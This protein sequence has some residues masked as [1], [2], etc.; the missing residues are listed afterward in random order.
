MA[1]EKLYNSSQPLVLRWLLQV[2]EFLASL[3]LAVVLI[4]S[5]AVVLAFATVVESVVGTSGVQ[6]AIY[7]TRAFAALL[8][9]LAI[10]IFCAASVRFPWK[11]H[12]TG[13]VITHIGLLTLLAGSAYSFR[14]SLNSQMIVFLNGSSQTA[15][16]QDYGYIV[17]E[18]LPNRDEALTINF[19]PGPFHWNEPEYSRRLQQIKLFIR[20]FKSPT[21]MVKAA[22]GYDDLALHEPELLHEQEGLKVEAIDYYA[23]AVNRRLP[24]VELKFENPGIGTKFPMQLAYREIHGGD[25]Q[26]G[27]RRE[28]FMGLGSVLYWREPDSPD[29]AAFLECVPEVAVEGDGAVVVWQAGELFHIPIAQLQTLADR[30]AAY[31]LEDGWSVQLV[32][33][34]GARRVAPTQPLYEKFAWK[35]AESAGGLVS[36]G[37]QVTLK[38]IGPDSESGVEIDRL[39]EEPFYQA[40]DLP[41]DMR[42][43]FY[44]PEVGGRID[45]VEGT[46]GHLFYRAWQQKIARVVAVGQ[47]TPG[48]PVDTWS[49]GGG[50]RIWQ[51]TVLRHGGLES[52]TRDVQN[53]EVPILGTSGSGR[54]SRSIQIVSFRGPDPQKFDK[55]DPRLNQQVKLRV[56][57]TAEGEEHSEEFWLQQIVPLEF[58]RPD[59]KQ[60]QPIDIGTDEPLF[61][62]YKGKQTEVGV[63]IKLLDFDLEVDPGTMKAG[64]YTSHVV[65]VDVRDEEEIKQ[66]RE[67]LEGLSGAEKVQ[68]KAELDAQ[69]NRLTKDYLMKLEDKSLAQVEELAA[70]H[71][72]LKLRLVTM[73]EPLDYSDD[74]G[75]NLR[76][77][78]ENYYPPNSLGREELATG[79]RVNSDPGR[80]IKYI[81]CWFVCFGIFVMFYMRAYFFKSIRKR[82]PAKGRATQQPQTENAEKPASATASV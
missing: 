45:L 21:R 10:N 62:S 20:A 66:L 79:F 74:T 75:R 71:D 1:R 58:M 80:W 23:S 56:T 48:K 37:P 22:F 17:L 18:N 6:Y 3:K 44:H 9:L 47:A 73:N 69:T 41:A 43:E 19:R 30:D 68:A 33:Y 14:T 61:C 7:H 42:V 13:F 8:A 29:M 2:Y 31:E 77:F 50:D 46:D 39:A 72:P 36:L 35:L 57:W 38:L 11:R 34:R 40:G 5:L 26:V 64:N 28:D 27:Y 16:D 78:Q 51:M 53:F 15:F 55:Q 76:Y 25:S 60:V 52:A 81:G 65:L 32:D 54:E 49:T 4:A 63:A 82:P 24:F 59:E 12:Q 67:E 70:E